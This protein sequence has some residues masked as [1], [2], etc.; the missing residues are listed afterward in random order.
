MLSVA[1]RVLVEE[2]RIGRLSAT[3]DVHITDA[4]PNAVV[5]VDARAIPV[6]LPPLVH[7]AEPG[8]LVLRRPAS[9]WSHC[10]IAASQQRIHG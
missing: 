3:V 5:A 7:S 2:L 1:C 6:S 8:L 10:F 4:A 9:S